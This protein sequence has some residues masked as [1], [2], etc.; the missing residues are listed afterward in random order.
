MGH[1]VADVLLGVAEPGGRLPTTWPA[2]GPQPV[3]AVTPVDGRLE[4]REGIHVG[5]RGWLRAGL[6]P[7]YPFGHGLGYTRW[8][9]SDLRTEAPGAD[10]DGAVE[11]TV[12]NL[13][14]RP[15]KQ[16]VQVY[17]SRSDSAVERPARW[18]AGHAVVRCGPG[19]SRGLRIQVPARA[20]AHWS[21]GWQLEPGRYDVLVGTSSADLPLRGRFEVRSQRSQPPSLSGRDSG[22]ETSW[23]PL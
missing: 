12:R 15:G 9:L 11:V 5:H 1:A 4:Y 2:D 17:L 18:L 22:R 3:A 7:A 8:S 23:I 20:L 19:D 21:D 13:G 16:V 6:S 14:P 10:H